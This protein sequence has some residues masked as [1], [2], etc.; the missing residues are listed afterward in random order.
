[1]CLGYLDEERVGVGEVEGKDSGEGSPGSSLRRQEGPRGGRA[2][3]AETEA[4]GRDR[5]FHPCSSRKRSGFYL[6]SLG[7]PPLGVEGTTPGPS[8]RTLGAPIHLTHPSRI[9]ARQAQ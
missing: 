5:A 6:R 9:L 2:A 8:S 3:G 1:M 4:S 7:A